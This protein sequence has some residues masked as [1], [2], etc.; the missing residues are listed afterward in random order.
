MGGCKRTLKKINMKKFTVLVSILLSLNSISQNTVAF[1]NMETWNWPGLWFGN[2]FNSTWATNFS[3]SP[4]ESAVIYGASN[5]SSAF[6]QDWYVL[7]NIVGLDPTSTYEFRFRLA[8]YRVTS[9]SSTRGVDVGDFVDVQLSYDGG[10]TYISELRITGNNNAYWDYN[11]NGVVNHIADGAF[12][13]NI[14]PL[15][16]I[17]RSGAGNQQFTGPSVIALQ[18]PAGITQVAVDILCRVNSAGEEWWLDNIELIEIPSSPLPITLISF[19]GTQQ[20]NSNLLEWKTAS[21]Q[22]NSH[23]ILEHSTNGIFDGAS[24]INIQQGAGNSQTPQTYLFVDNNT[25]PTINYYIL[26]QVYF[27]GEYEIFNT[28]SIDNRNKAKVVKTINMMGQWVN[29]NYRGVVIDIYSDDSIEKR[30]QY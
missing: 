6:E 15:G 19:T 5:G 8:S 1:D 3:V 13:N 26:T 7:P 4:I 28:I 2:T 25:Q 21:E 18:L 16:D 14:T 30:L 9:T 20:S 29:E 23:F 10:F 12:Q 11:V 27:N 17:Y 24:A 22:N